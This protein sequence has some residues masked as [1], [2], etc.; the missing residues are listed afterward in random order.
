ML[1]ELPLDAVRKGDSAVVDIVKARNKIGKM[2]IHGENEDSYM[3]TE[4]AYT[5]YYL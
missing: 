2:H 5:P 3:I 4:T 1:Y